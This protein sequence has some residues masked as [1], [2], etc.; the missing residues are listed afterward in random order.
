MLLQVT[1][2]DIDGIEWVAS[3]DSEHGYL[4]IQE[5]GSNDFGERTFITKVDPA[6]G[7]QTFYLLAMSGG[8]DN[9]RNKAGVGIPAGVNNGDFSASSARAI[10]GLISPRHPSM[11]EAPS[12]P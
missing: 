3:S 7:L 10:S 1:F 6:A 11:T 5:D 2:E 8:D 9:T 4:I 12:R